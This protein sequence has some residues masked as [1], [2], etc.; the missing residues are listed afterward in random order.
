MSAT[1]VLYSSNLLS[2][3][4]S[5]DTSAPISSNPETEFYGNLI[6]LYICGRTRGHFIPQVFP[7]SVSW[8]YLLRRE[9]LQSLACLCDYKKGR[10]IVTAMA[11]QQTDIGIVYL[12]ASC[13]PDGMRSTERIWSGYLRK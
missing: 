6:M 2:T 1:G 13:N 4:M 10:P 8:E 3:P 5:L 12:F 11:L 7:P 9:F